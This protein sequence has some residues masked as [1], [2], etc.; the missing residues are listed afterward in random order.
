MSHALSDPYD[1]MHAEMNIG[2][3]VC[4]CVCVCLCACTIQSS[5]AFWSELLTR[6]ESR[7]QQWQLQFQVR[8]TAEVWDA[9]S[10]QTHV[11]LLESH[12]SCSSRYATLHMYTTHRHAHDIRT[13]FSRTLLA[14]GL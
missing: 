6:S 10:I 8:V 13:C 9:P 7:V 12:C 4:L 2:S 14:L 11:S 5:A 3:H 1:A